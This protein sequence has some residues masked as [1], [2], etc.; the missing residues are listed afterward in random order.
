VAPF[1][2]KPFFNGFSVPGILLP[3][4][5]NVVIWGGFLGWYCRRRCL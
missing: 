1:T 5:F 2:G 3:I 4:L